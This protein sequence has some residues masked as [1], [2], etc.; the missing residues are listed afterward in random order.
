[1]CHRFPKRSSVDHARSGLA[2][3][4]TDANFIN[5]IKIRPILHRTLHL[6]GSTFVQ[7]VE[8]A[9]LLVAAMGVDEQELGSILEDVQGEPCGLDELGQGLDGQQGS[10]ERNRFKKM[11][12]ITEEELAKS[13]LEDCVVVRMAV[14][15]H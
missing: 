13:S 5:N 15:D 14:K 1:M 2:P 8:N 3:F 9:N 12:K 7:E 4:F 11:Y 10:I 6:P